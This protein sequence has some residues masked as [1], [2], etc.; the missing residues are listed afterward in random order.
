MYDSQRFS[1]LVAAS[2]NRWTCASTLSGTLFSTSS[3]VLFDWVGD[4]GC[5]VLLL[6]AEVAAD[7]AEPGA[8]SRAV[9]LCDIRRIT[10]TARSFKT[11]G[12]KKKG[13]VPYVSCW[14]IFVQCA[15]SLV[16][17]GAHL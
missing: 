13:S 10:L 1:W 6:F 15:N 3:C 7:A 11:E 5:A 17:G 16:L 9:S 8:P 2:I 14:A 12:K 4:T